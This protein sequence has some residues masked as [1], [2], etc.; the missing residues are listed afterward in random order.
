MYFYGRN[1]PAQVLMV[2]KMI[3]SQTVTV[4]REAAGV[5]RRRLVVFPH[6]ALNQRMWDGCFSEISGWHG[7]GALSQVLVEWMR[8]LPSVHRVGVAAADITIIH[9]LVVGFPLEALTEKMRNSSCSENSSWRGERN[10][11]QKLLRS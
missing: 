3:S 7:R 4:R 9:W 6:K 10:V 8:G 5:A 11:I 2:G 1:S